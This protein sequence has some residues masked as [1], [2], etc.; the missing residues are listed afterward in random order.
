MRS[1]TN[2]EIQ[3]RG[4]A[5]ADRTK[6][7]EKEKGERKSK[8]DKSS[9]TGFFSNLKEAIKLACLRLRAVLT[10]PDSGSNNRSYARQ[11]D[12]ALIGQAPALWQLKIKNE[13]KAER[14]KAK[15]WKKFA[16]PIFIR[17]E[18]RE[19]FK[20]GAVEYK[21]GTPLQ[22]LRGLEK[23]YL[24]RTD[25]VA[26]QMTEEDYIRLKEWI[27]SQ[28]KEAKLL[29]RKA[30]GVTEIT[31]EISS[32]ETLEANAKSSPL[33]LKNLKMRHLK[34]ELHLSDHEYRALSDWLN[35]SSGGKRDK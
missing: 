10:S 23:R 4:D 35:K 26:D 32:E 33:T 6:P 25:G 7:L 27:K 15:D 5:Y 14:N 3:R 19:G 20:P 9:V 2:W 13:L 22:E 18:G 17:E 28:F 24:A 11:N 31:V 8:E 12:D 1:L 21:P 29:E 34:G 16:R 30:K